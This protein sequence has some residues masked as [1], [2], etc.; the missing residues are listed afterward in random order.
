MFHPKAGGWIHPVHLWDRGGPNASDPSAYVE[1][2][3]K[4]SGPWGRGS[5]ECHEP[6]AAALG[7]PIVSEFY[8]QKAKQMIEE[9]TV[10]DRGIKFSSKD[11]W[12]I[13]KYPEV[14]WGKKK[15]FFI[16]WRE[17]S[18]LSP[19][20][21]TS[22]FWRPLPSAFVA[23]WSCH[24]DRTGAGVIVYSCTPMQC[25]AWLGQG[26]CPEC[27]K[28]KDGH[29]KMCR[30]TLVDWLCVDS[31]IVALLWCWQ[32][33]TDRRDCYEL[34][35]YTSIVPQIFSAPVTFEIKGWIS[36]YGSCQWWRWR[37]WLRP[38]RYAHILH[39]LKV[40]SEPKKACLYNSYN[41]YLWI[42]IMTP[43][44]NCACCIQLM[45]IDT[46]TSDFFGPGECEEDDEEKLRVED[47]EQEPT[48]NESSRCAA[49]HR[50]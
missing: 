13:L 24:C 31:Y 27:W 6:R 5:N 47:T 11:T 12:G 25:W 46:N 7:S 1:P 21:S 44:Q 15:S 14:S 50:K 36:R 35:I 10:I 37:R 34:L 32:S 41:T 19:A 23:P 39:I 22:S 33:I 18:V 26:V 2:S 16:S 45:I 28:C 30:E 48:A 9:I 29:R 43:M 8:Y 42:H 40:T 4:W 3:A 17:S 49:T 20:W 38:W